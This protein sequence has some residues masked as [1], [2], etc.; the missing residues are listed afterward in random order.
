[1]IQIL[2]LPPLIGSE[3][4]AGLVW[5]T[6]SS[7]SSGCLRVHRPLFHTAAQMVSLIAEAKSLGQS[8]PLW[9]MKHPQNM[10]IFMIMTEEK[11][12][13]GL[14]TDAELSLSQ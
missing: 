5:I 8:N 1:M 11:E 12:Y 10:G 13:I 9:E 7:P 14:R 3:F 2:Q 4:D 6:F